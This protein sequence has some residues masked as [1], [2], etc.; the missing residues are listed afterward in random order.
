[1]A[2]SLFPP[3]VG[4]GG[5]VSSFNTRTG[6]VTLGSAD[7]TG[8]L[9]FTPYDA[10]NPTGFITAASLTPYLT[11][12]TA[13]A[14]Y[15]TIAGMSAYLTANQTITLSGDVT[16]SGA[17]SITATLANTAVS[18]GSYTNANITV[19]AKGRVT[20][21]S[22][23]SSSGSITNTESALSANVQLAVSNTWYDGPGVSLA[24]GTWLVIGHIT[25][26]RTTTTASQV[27]ARIT[28]G[29]THYASTQYYHASVSNIS[30]N[31]SMSSIVT[32]AS[33]TTILLQAATS[34]GAT[35]SLM[36]AATSANS[37]GNNATKITA[38]K[39]A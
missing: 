9:G 22:N 36:R 14:T 37:S 39:L 29:T 7:V 5:G 24:A 38:I 21:A 10:A 18:P 35:S 33:T 3:S 34:A 32:L 12:A 8:A 15:Q 2:I 1:M 6:A 25:H 17:T 4:G 28:D 26:Q 27:F 16:G 11:S 20:S 30:G 19:D 13:A 23:G 31:L